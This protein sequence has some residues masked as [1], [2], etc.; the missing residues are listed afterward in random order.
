MTEK[1]HHDTSWPC[2]PFLA[3]PFLPHLLFSD[4]S[5]CLKSKY[6]VLNTQAFP[7]PLPF[8]LS[9][10][11]CFFAYIVT[12][13]LSSAAPAISSS[14][15][16]L[17]LSLVLLILQDSIYM[18]HLAANAVSSPPI[19]PW[20][21]F[22]VCQLDFQLPVAATLRALSGHRVRS[23]YVQCW[24]R[25][26]GTNLMSHSQGPAADNQKDCFLGWITPSHVLSMGHQHL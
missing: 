4:D 17:L 7:A 16:G 3:S 1:T 10:L 14:Q 5:C 2:S 19:S 13:C 12:G 15:Y 24:L 9:S 25:P 26:Q 18:P 11:N 23:A 21:I 6:Q 22:H 8:I 20:H